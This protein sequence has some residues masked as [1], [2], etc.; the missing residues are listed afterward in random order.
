MTGHP[1]KPYCNYTITGAARIRYPAMGDASR[2]F[3]KPVESSDGIEAIE[4][5]F[6]LASIFRHTC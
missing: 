1:S 5:S 6:V 4:C 2:S 3:T